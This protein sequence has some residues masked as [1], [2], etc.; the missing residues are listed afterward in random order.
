[1][2]D[3]GCVFL[4]RVFTSPGWMLAFLNDELIQKLQDAFQ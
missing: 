1:M 4:C 2:A 3:L